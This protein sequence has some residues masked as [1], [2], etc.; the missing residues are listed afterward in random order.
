MF[1]INL[2]AHT[3]QVR[4]ALLIFD[5]IQNWNSI[6]IKVSADTVPTKNINMML[7]KLLFEELKSTVVYT[8]KLLTEAAYKSK[9]LKNFYLL[10]K[11]VQKFYKT[12]AVWP[13]SGTGTK[14][15]AVLIVKRAVRVLEEKQERGSLL[16]WL[17]KKDKIWEIKS[18]WMK[19]SGQQVVVG[20]PWLYTTFLYKKI[21]F[22]KP[23]NWK[24]HLVRI[25]TLSK[26][27]GTALVFTA[28]RTG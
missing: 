7:M 3:R 11:A 21:F 13:L 28:V 27:S 26:V 2:C 20:L 24:Q 9:G 14:V 4:Y 23:R 16:L 1:S 25:L 15:S 6:F 17:K 8:V 12:T 18:S 10:Y 19:T 22:I 5:C